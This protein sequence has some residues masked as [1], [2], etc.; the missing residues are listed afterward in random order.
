MKSTHV[1]P[2]Y[3]ETARAEP[4]VSTFWKWIDSLLRYNSAF[5]ELQAQTEYY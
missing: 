4:E 2:K 1:P 3:V 5:T